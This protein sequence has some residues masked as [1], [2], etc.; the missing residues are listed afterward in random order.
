VSQHRYLDA[1]LNGATTAAQAHAQI[2][3]FI[4]VIGYKQ[5]AAA[6]GWMDGR[7]C[8]QPREAKN[9]PGLF[10]LVGSWNYRFSS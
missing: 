8:G 10:L 3:W 7:D 4:L 9:T 5:P 1:K 2:I 6:T